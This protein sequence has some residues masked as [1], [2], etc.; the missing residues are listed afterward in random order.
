MIDVIRNVATRPE[1]DQMR[2]IGGRTNG[3]DFGCS[4]IK[5]AEVMCNLLE[6]IRSKYLAIFDLVQNDRVMCWLGLI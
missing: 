4:T 5:V 6:L 2:V 1:T 3:N